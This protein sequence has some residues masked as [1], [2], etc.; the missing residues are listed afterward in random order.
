MY[1]PGCLIA[2]PF[3]VSGSWSL[4]GCDLHPAAS[5]AISKVLALP[6]YLFHPF[7]CR[8]NQA[9]FYSMDSSPKTPTGEPGDAVEMEA[10]LRSV[11]SSKDSSWEKGDAINA[12]VTSAE[13]HDDLDERRDATKS[14]HEDA[15][16]M[17]RMGR[18]QQLVRQ[19]RLLSVA[20]FVAIATAAWEIGIFTITPGLTDG[21]R[22]LLLYSVIWN[23]VGFGP[24]YLSMAEMASMAPIAGAQ[25]HWVSEFA[26][27]SLQKI[28]SYFTG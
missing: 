1:T 22:P 21:G 4:H 5:G 2:E 16:N 15:L 28:L 10:H 7:S 6:L 25:Y 9:D 19:F 24:I 23:F 18:T 13:V 8:L 26:P 12:Q 20:S 17:R 14:T 27:E 11:V 3:S